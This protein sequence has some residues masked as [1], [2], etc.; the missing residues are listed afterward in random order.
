[1]PVLTHQLHRPRDAQLAVIPL[2]LRAA[3]AL[4]EKLCDS[5]GHRTGIRDRNRLTLTLAAVL[6][7]EVRKDVLLEPQHRIKQ[8]TDLLRSEIRRKPGCKVLS[9]IVL[10]RAS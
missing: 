8:R 2:L 5:L 6:A 10:G 7:V 1:M 3:K 9:R 4:M